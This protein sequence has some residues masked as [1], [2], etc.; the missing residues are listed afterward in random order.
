M[1]RYPEFTVETRGY[2]A[3]CDRVNAASAKTVPMIRIAITEAAFAA[4]A[5]TMP[6]GDV[7]YERDL[8]A[9][10][11]RLIWV[12]AAVADKLATMCGP[13]ESYS[14]VILRLV[15]IEVRSST[16]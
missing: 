10:G 6:F 8:D 14:D 4:I 11:Q 2:P 9:Q 13:G 12:E 7:G 1:S 16:R 5:D 15:E 3:W